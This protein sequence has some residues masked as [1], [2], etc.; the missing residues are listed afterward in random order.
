[1]L[2]Q[3]RATP[4]KSFYHDTEAMPPRPKKGKNREGK[5]LP[6]KETML[7]RLFRELRLPTERI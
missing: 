4:K 6:K 2:E 3:R 1:M 7:G 5:E